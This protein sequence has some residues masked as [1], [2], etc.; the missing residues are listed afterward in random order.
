M[1]LASAGRC[2]PRQVT[3]GTAGP[4]RG[5]EREAGVLS[6]WANCNS[7]PESCPRGGEESLTRT[8]TAPRDSR[9]SESFTSRA[10]REQEGKAASRRDGAAASEDEPNPA[11]SRS[12]R[13]KPTGPPAPCCRTSPGTPRCHQPLFSTSTSLHSAWGAPPRTCRDPMGANLGA[14]ALSQPWS[15]CISPLGVSLGLGVSPRGH[16]SLLLAPN[17]CGPSLSQGLGLK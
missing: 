1:I 15:C 2:Q 16:P 6:L 7:S 14:P 11:A 12:Q 3:A 17:L 10:Q 4:H 5:A 13:T 9:F 8:V